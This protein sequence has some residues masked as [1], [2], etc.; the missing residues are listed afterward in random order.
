MIWIR[1]WF[2]HFWIKNWSHIATH[3]VVGFLVLVGVTDALR[4]RLK[5]PLFGSGWNYAGLIIVHQENMYWLTESDFS[6]D[7][8][9]PGW[10]SW[11]HVTHKSAAIWSAHIQRL[12][13]A[14][15]IRWLLSS[16]TGY[17]SW[18]IVHSYLLSAA[19]A[20]FLW[21]RELVFT[22]FTSTKTVP[23]HSRELE[24]SWS[25]VVNWRKIKLLQ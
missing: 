12:P 11:H 5:H 18:S 10:W 15:C 19:Y 25:Q 6:Y 21:A 14:R 1:V 23:K 13:D 4:K 17:S 9:F 20:A 16:N 7:V 3:H 2:L 24:I 8:I 22:I